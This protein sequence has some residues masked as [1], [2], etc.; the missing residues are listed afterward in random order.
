MPTVDVA[1][2]GFAAVG[3]TITSGCSS[4][5]IP[6]LQNEQRAEPEEQLGSSI[7]DRRHWAIPT[8]GRALS[9]RLWTFVAA[10]T[11]V[12]CVDGRVDSGVVKPA[13]SLFK[14]SLFPAG[15]SRFCAENG[16]EKTDVWQAVKGENGTDDVLICRGK[17]FGYLRTEKEYANFE[18][19][20]EWKYPKDANGNSG[21]LI[22]TGKEDKIWPN[23]IQVQLHGPTAGS[24]FPSADAKTDN[25]LMVRDLS[26]P[27]GQWN[28]CVITAKAGRVS[29]VINGKKVGEVTGCKPSL[30]SIAL[31]SEGSEVHFR[32]IMLKPLE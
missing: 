4:N 5:V 2:S 10:L 32:R 19:R 21:V 30:G 27:V 7:A 24:I 17:P 13:V 28:T 3:V 25:K 22:Y 8:F 11:I 9:M 26:K 23:A 29:V 14:A 1:D 31:Q 18:F 15:W 16:T 6:P 12:C 20:L